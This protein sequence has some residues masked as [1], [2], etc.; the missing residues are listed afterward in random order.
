M[1]PPYHQ[2]YGGA[3]Q[4]QQQP[5]GYTDDHFYNDDHFYS[6]SNNSLDYLPNERRRKN[7]SNSPVPSSPVS[8]S[9][10]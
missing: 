1:T 5:R 7:S 8:S 10:R 9:Y 4:S 3:Q 2:Q 6:G